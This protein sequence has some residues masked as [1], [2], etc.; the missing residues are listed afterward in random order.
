M[1]AKFLC[2]KNLWAR[3]CIIMLGLAMVFSC[4]NKAEND[5][6]LLAKD[7]TATADLRRINADLGGTGQITPENFEKLKGL[8]EKY[9]HSEAIG[10]TYKAALMAREDWAGLENLLTASQ[11]GDNARDD[12]TLLAKVYIKLGNFERSAEVLRSFGNEASTDVEIR[13]LSALCNFNVEKLSE[14]A[15]DLDAVWNEIVDQKRIDDINLR[16]MIFF[17]TKDYERAIS[18]LQRSLELQ[19]GNPVATNT[20]SRVHA[21][22]GD[23]AKAESYR[24]ETEKAQERSERETSNKLQ[25]V[26][27]VR[28]IETA[29]NEKRYDDVIL[30]A[31]KML[32]VSD[33]KNKSAVL[34]YITAAEAELKKQNKQ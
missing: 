24:I 22:M 27:L 8:R 32:E 30:I 31:K 29:W 33:D 3:L 7:T 34:K 15:A 13:S 5:A 17:R 16:A 21:A 14:A 28:T 25:F 26:G 2:Y 18:T 9:P 11:P 19:P 23:T 1:I 4:Q 6:T 20:M 12:K 10:K